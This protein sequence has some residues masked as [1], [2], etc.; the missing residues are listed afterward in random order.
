LLVYFSSLRAALNTAI[1]TA[2]KIL[3]INTAYQYCLSI[4]LSIDYSITTSTQLLYLYIIVF[5]RP[6]SII[7]G[8]SASIDV[9]QQARNEQHIAELMKSAELREK[10]FIHIDE[11]LKKNNDDHISLKDKIGMKKILI[12]FL[13]PKNTLYPGFIVNREIIEEALEHVLREKA[14]KCK[15]VSTNIKEKNITVKDFHAFFPILLLFVKLWNIFEAV[16]GL[17]VQDRKILKGEFMKIRTELHKID[18]LT[19]IN[20][21]DVSEEKWNDVWNE[22]NVNGDELISFHEVC[23]Y[24][25]S[26][27][28]RAFN[29]DDYLTISAAEEDSSLVEQTI[30]EEHPT[31]AGFDGLII[32]PEHEET[33]KTE[34]LIQGE[35][36]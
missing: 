36:N 13:D 12:Y 25:L 31:G 23:K 1:N 30:L 32:R 7:M 2:I 18:E 21:H 11:Y 10:L 26:H 14:K 19:I 33:P 5:I 4:L 9:S 8:A 22:I 3:L 16:D 27:I 6:V 28:H 17:I 15:R 24:T 20:I 34:P 29:Y 35:N